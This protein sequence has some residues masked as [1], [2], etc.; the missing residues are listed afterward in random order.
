MTSKRSIS[1]PLALAVLALLAE[2]PMHPYEMASTMRERGKHHSIKLNYGSLY[3]VVD[4][5]ERHRLIVPVETV[6][7]GRRPERTIYALTDAGRAKLD[8]WLRDLLRR[9]IKEYPQFEAGLSLMAVLP[10]EAVVELLRERV[11][12]LEQAIA[13]E[14]ATMDDAAAQGLPQV[15]LIEA[16]YALMLKEAELRWV[17]DL[18]RAIE[19]EE[20]T[21]LDLWRQFHARPDMIQDGGEREEEPVNE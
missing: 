6:R 1:N 18:V 11:E 15:F 10:P 5:L 12:R 2:Q 7:E 4:A 13:E 8:G 14:R 16:D 3:T 21:G 19:T 17:R 9:P 20:L